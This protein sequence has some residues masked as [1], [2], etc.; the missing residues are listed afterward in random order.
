MILLVNT[1]EITH[2]DRLAE[3]LLVERSVEVRVEQSAV[4]DGFTDNPA[5]KS[6]V[7]KVMDVAKS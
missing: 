2:V 5:D 4:V 3:N 1:L 6:E 7:F